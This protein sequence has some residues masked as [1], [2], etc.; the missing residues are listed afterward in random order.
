MD[1]ATTAYSIV[2]LNYD[3]V[4]ENITDFLASSFPSET[5]VNSLI[6]S[7]LH[8]SVESDII[9]P[10]WNKNVPEGIRANWIRAYESLRKAN[11]IR[12]LGYSLPITDN[13][14]K[15]LLSISLLD[16]ENLKRIDIITLDNQNLARQ[17]YEK[18]FEPFPNF[19]FKNASIEAYLSH[20]TSSKG[21]YLVG[22]FLYARNRA[23]DANPNYTITSDNKVFE[24]L[25]ES[26]MAI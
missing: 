23:S 21:K 2:T 14:I 20:L 24:E 9:P 11:E 1:P 25:H 17:R 5:N 13:Y 16:S 15:Y 26:F 3:R 8:G 4:I 10:T 22:D 6:I 7:K 19:R 18:M 12:I